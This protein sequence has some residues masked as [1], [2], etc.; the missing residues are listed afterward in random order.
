MLQRLRSLGLDLMEVRT[1][2]YEVT[3]DEAQPLIVRPRP[4]PD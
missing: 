2:L 4:E 1:S 3:D